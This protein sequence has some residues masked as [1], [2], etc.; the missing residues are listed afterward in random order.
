MLQRYARRGAGSTAFLLKLAFPAAAH[1]ERGAPSTAQILL[2]ATHAARGVK[3]G[4]T[5]QWS[6][7][8]AHHGPETMWVSHTPPVSE[9]KGWA[10]HKVDSWLSPLEADLTAGG[11]DPHGT[12][13]G[14]HMHGINKGVAYA[15][16]EGNLSIRSVDSAVASFGAPLAVPTPLQPPDTSLGVHWALVG[17]I[18]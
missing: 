3:L 11:C 16:A 5:L 9:R 14:V 10:M 4:V 8:T 7:K 12:T 1:S 13:C 15:G 18:A 17:N 2:N 6:N